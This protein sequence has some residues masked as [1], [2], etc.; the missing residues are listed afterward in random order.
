M[1]NMLAYHC[2]FLKDVEKRGA[3]DDASPLFEPNN[4]PLALPPIRTDLF[5]REA[6]EHKL[7]S[8]AF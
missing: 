8:A 2:V 1:R 7:D 3:Q 5:C 6:N 4:A